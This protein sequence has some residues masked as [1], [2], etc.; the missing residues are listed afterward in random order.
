MNDEHIDE[1]LQALMG[2]KDY[3]PV[4]LFVLNTIY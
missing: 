2:D 3:S 1:N 4:V